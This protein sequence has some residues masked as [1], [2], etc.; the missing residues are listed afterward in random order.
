VDAETQ[1]WAVSV[2]PARAI[3]PNNG[4]DRGQIA[5]AAALALDFPLL[6]DTGR[7][8]CLL[9]GSVDTIQQASQRWTFLID[10]DG[11]LRSVD[12]DVQSRVRTHGAD[13]LAK[14]RELGMTQ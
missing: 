14:M 13:C 6:P 11:I 4:Q 7:N 10:K 12:K 9:Y 1:I 2:D 5:F 8:L 3:D